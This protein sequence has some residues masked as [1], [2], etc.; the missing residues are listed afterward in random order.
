M[1]RNQS[2]VTYSVYGDALDAQGNVTKYYNLLSVIAQQ[3]KHFYPSWRIRF[4]H[5]I[6]HKQQAERRLLCQAYCENDHVDLCD[7][8]DVV[9]RLS[10]QNEAATTPVSAVQLK[11]LNRMLWRYLPMLDPQVDRMMVR[12]TDSELSDREAVAVGQWLASPATFHV[13]RDHQNHCNPR[14]KI[15]GGMFGA[16]T[17][18]RRDVIDSLIRVIVNFG[19]GQDVW[20]RDQKLLTAVLWPTVKDDAMIHDSYC[21]EK[22]WNSVA[23]TPFPTRRV[24]GNFVADRN[25]SAWTKPQQCPLKCRPPEHPD[26]DYC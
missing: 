13:M 20:G 15:L 21:C 3:V 22:S 7:V 1:G 26:W 23:A 9:R 6:D 8:N 24:A 11:N 17:R 16:K 12:D 4:Y 5:S 18:Q 2:V 19:W 14:H 10:R 25:D